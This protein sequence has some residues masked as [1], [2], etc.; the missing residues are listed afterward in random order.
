LSGAAAVCNAAGADP[1]WNFFP[2]SSVR[3]NAHGDL[4]SQT[5]GSALRR[6]DLIQERDEA[7]GSREIRELP[8]LCTDPQVQIIVTNREI[9]GKYRARASLV[10]LGWLGTALMAAAVLA[11]IGKSL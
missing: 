5:C 3:W 2:A 9:M 7:I 6:Q 4:G 10:V 11:M 8:P 1:E